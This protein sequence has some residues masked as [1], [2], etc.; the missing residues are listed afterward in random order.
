MENG[1]TP[2]AEYPDENDWKDTK[3]NKTYAIPNYMTKILPGDEISEGINYLNSRQREVSS[4]VDTW[5]EDYVKYN[6]HDVEPV[7]L[8]LL[9]RER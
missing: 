7:Q 4:V 2:P 5:A 3:T 1:V 6:G 8:F 9:G